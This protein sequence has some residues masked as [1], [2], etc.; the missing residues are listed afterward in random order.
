[1][2][3]R[4]YKQF[5][6]TVQE[7][8]N[9]VGNASQE[10][11]NSEASTN[12]LIDLIQEPTDNAA[13][14][15]LSTSSYPYDI[16]LSNSPTDKSPI[17]TTDISATN[18]SNNEVALYKE[19]PPVEPSATD[20]IEVITASLLSNK[21]IN[22]LQLVLDRSGNSLE[23]VLEALKTQDTD[24]IADSSAPGIYAVLT[25]TDPI[26]FARIITSIRKNC[27]ESSLISL[28]SVIEIKKE[29]LQEYKRNKLNQIR[30]G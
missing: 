7:V 4:P 1:M 28:A 19:A 13:S 23:S 3:G 16:S 10:P 29:S 22:V 17:E 21:Y 14:A 26:I 5:K 2:S 6:Y 12:T 24:R 20:R 8:Y 9:P 25:D 15:S 18:Q 27:I 30:E 11:P